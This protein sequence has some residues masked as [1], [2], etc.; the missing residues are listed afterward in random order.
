MQ[1]RILPNGKHMPCQLF[2]RKFESQM[3]SESKETKQSVCKRSTV[4]LTE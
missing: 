3:T 1:M 2:K 4:I